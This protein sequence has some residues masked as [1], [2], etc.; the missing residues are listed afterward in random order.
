VGALRGE[1]KEILLGPGCAPAPGRWE[2]G[3]KDSDP[4]I[5]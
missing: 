2:E 4:L 3:F 5:C 1:P